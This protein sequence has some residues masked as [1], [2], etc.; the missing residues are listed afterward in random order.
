[1][2]GNLA[3]GLWKKALGLASAEEISKIV[4]KVLRNED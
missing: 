4:Q 1:M 3:T 2:I